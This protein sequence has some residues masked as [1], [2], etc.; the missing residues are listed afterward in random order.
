MGTVPT[1]LW[2]NAPRMISLLVENKSYNIFNQA[3]SLFLGNII[4]DCVLG[5]IT[6]VVH[7]FRV[8]LERVLVHSITRRDIIF[9]RSPISKYNQRVWVHFVNIFWSRPERTSLSRP[10][11]F[12]AREMLTNL[13]VRA[14]PIQFL[15]L[16]GSKFSFSFFYV[17]NNFQALDYILIVFYLIKLHYTSHSITV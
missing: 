16:V 1:K 8:S 9:W 11:N 3:T 5:S 7:S 14:Y 17:Y 12:W 6:S 15:A 4:D 13:P 2:L 10:M